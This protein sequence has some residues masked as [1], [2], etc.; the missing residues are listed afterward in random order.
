MPTGSRSDV[1]AP[2]RSDPVI[3]GLSNAIGGPLGAHAAPGRRWWTPLR[4]VLAM[5]AISC[6]LAWLQKAACR[7]NPWAD[8]FQYTRGCYSDVFALYFAERLNEGAVPYADHPV[9]YPV[10]IG[11]LMHLAAQVTS[12]VPEPL[13]PRTFFDLT[14]GLLACCALVV[15]VCTVRLAG[16]RP[17][18]AALFAA[19]P[20]LVLHA[21]TN[22]DLAAVALASL[23]LLAWARSRPTLAG[24]LIGLGAATK[25]YPAVLLFPLMMLCLRERR[26]REFIRT[27]TAAVAVWAA[28]NLPVYLA[29]P[30]S[31]LRFFELNRTRPIDW[32][33]IWMVL[34][35]LTPLTITTEQVNLFSAVGFLLVLGGVAWLALRAPVRPRVA[36]L[37]FL[38]VA[39]FL[40]TS[41]VFS[42]QFV[43]WLVPLAALAHPRWA[44]FLAWQVAEAVLLVF[45]FAMFIGQGQSGQ[46]VPL[47]WFLRVVLLRD[48]V[49]VLLCALVVRG[50]L[51]PAD[52]PVRAGD[53]DSDAD[54]AA[55]ILGR[56]PR[57]G[58]PADAP[59]I[60]SI[61]GTAST[62]GEPGRWYSS[63]AA[64]RQLT[65]DGAAPPP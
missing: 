36:S 33:S 62:S 26:W 24:A 7:T 61:S 25:F 10:G 58:H 38:T 59:D 31:W 30:Q 37:A 46:G 4:V 23:G 13:R 1:A 9:E 19:A 50:I 65:S 48:A 28:V 45:R 52:D 49:L 54:P 17:W 11:G 39:G 40:L 56:L 21:Y 44:P 12:L 51:R 42:P 8:D 60:P 16:R 15:A 2:S 43:L 14:A 20:A 5:T 22:W 63:D 41:K 34:D 18:D 47:E 3:A 6:A 29:W 53:G 27:G 35:R 57:D 55:G 32:D 64:D